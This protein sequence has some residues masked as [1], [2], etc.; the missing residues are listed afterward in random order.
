MGA[1]QQQQQQFFQQQQQQQFY[2]QQ[3]QQQAMSP[4]PGQAL[5]A[6]F[7]A[8]GAMPM[9]LSPAGFPQQLPLQAAPAN[10]HSSAPLGAPAV[11]APL[12][13]GAPGV[14]RGRMAMNGAAVMMAPGSPGRA[15]SPHQQ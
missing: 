3:Q 11:G 7:P 1:Q 13:P 15:R 10:W 14:P 8:A 12:G 6:Q 9:P 2:Q 4:V 5:Q